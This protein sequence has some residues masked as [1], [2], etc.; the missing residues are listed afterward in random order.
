M[1]TPSRRLRLSTLLAA[2][3]FALLAGCSSHGGHHG[4]GGDMNHGMRLSLSGASEVPA[5][6]TQATGMGMIRVG[7]DRSVSG[8]IMTSGL[9]GTMAHIHQGAPGTNGPVVI[10][11]TGLGNEWMV[12]AGSML[13]EAQYEAYKAGNLYVN[14][15]T[16]ANKGGEIRA[17]LRP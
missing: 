2:S 4:M 12:P 6:S 3:A 11:L 9:Q 8:R 5:V 10:G 13:T 14:V 1:K 16:D 7:S 17:Q 15:H